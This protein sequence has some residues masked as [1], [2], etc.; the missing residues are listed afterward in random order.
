MISSAH[1]SILFSH[2]YITHI[3]GYLVTRIPVDE[4][5]PTSTADMGMENRDGYFNLFVC[6]S[7]TNN[8][9]H[10]EVDLSLL[11]TVMKGCVNTSVN[12]RLTK[13]DQGAVVLT[14]SYVNQ[15]NSPVS[16]DTPVAVIHESD[17]LPNRSAQ[18]L[19]YYVPNLN[20]LNNVVEKMS[21]F[22][23]YITVTLHLPKSFNLKA[24]VDAFK[25][26]KAD[27]TKFAPI[28]LEDC[29]LELSVSGN[30]GRISST[31][32]GLRCSILPDYLESIPDEEEGEGDVYDIKSTFKKTSLHSHSVTVRSIDMLKLLTFRSVCD[33]CV[34]NHTEYMNRNS[35]T[36]FSHLQH[37]LVFYTRSHGAVQNKVFLPCVDTDH[38]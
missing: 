18:Y 9:I 14:T 2:T 17:N 30:N 24:A 16:V 12:M 22:S 11:I 8:K 29:V 37:H 32:P 20:I 35:Q 26:S 27:D 3:E 28:P 38:S 6:E 10:L 5:T 19:R 4:D 15:H 36:T 7:K 23:H 25:A 13:D 33:E 21:L 34:N 31:F 1:S